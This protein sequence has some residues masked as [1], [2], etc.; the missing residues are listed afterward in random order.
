MWLFCWTLWAASSGEKRAWQRSSREL[1]R[2]RA[3]V[4]RSTLHA[5]AD[6]LSWELSSSPFHHI[7]KYGHRS[8]APALLSAAQ[9]MARS[10]VHCSRPVNPVDVRTALVLFSIVYSDRFFPTR[11][12]R[13]I[14]V[15]P[16]EDLMIRH[17]LSFLKAIDDD[18]WEL[19]TEWAEIDLESLQR[20]KNMIL[21]RWLVAP[22]QSGWSQHCLKV[23][24][25]FLCIMYI[26]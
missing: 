20:Q 17:M 8:W 11:M 14:S 4:I 18:E 16:S 3:L 23:H 21:P 12:N 22:V 19:P 15:A 6:W 26:I 10:Q 7:F 5:C 25:T 24:P 13:G 2:R 9:W 1:R